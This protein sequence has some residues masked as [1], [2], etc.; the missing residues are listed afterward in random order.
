[1]NVVFTYPE[2]NHTSV[3]LHGILMAELTGAHHCTEAEYVSDSRLIIAIKPTKQFIQLYGY[4][5]II[6]PMDGDYSLDDLRLVHCMI[7]NSQEC[8]NWWREFGYT[9]NVQIIPQCWDPRLLERK[10]VFVRDIGWYGHIKKVPEDAPDGTEFNWATGYSEYQ[11]VPFIHK[12]HVCWNSPHFQR[13]IPQKLVTALALGATPILKTADQYKDLVGEW[14]CHRSQ[15]QAI[16]SGV[17]LDF[18][19]KFR[20]QSIALIYKQFFS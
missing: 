1:M 9:G 2:R 12:F 14:P 4:K 17:L 6:H 13:G 18:K 15:I 20:P 11:S 5:M 10:S 7:A 8:E 19:E 16:D 3:E